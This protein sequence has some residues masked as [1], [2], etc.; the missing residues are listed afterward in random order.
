[1]S[2]ER[3]L[4]GE[5]T[6]NIIAEKRGAIGWLTFNDAERH[7]AVSF[8]MWEAVP[9]VL[10]AFRE[11]SDIRAVVLTGAGTKS[12]VSGANISQFDN[13]RSGEDAVKAYEVVAEAAQLALYDFEK[14]TLARIQGYCIGGGLNIAL[15]CDIRVASPD[16]SFAIPAGRLGLGYRLTAIRNL[17]T[18][19][20]PANA[21]EIFL[22][23]ARYKADEAKALGLIQRVSDQGELDAALESYLEK[24]RA[25]APLTLKA[26]KKMIRQMQQLGPQVD[27]KAM[28]QMVLD[29][30][31][32]E[33]YAEGK[34]AFAEKRAPVFKGR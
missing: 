31:A 27:V 33:D 7:N 2:S 30:F 1:M 22:S 8:A 11:D 4:Q 14:P 17:V 24:I 9:I 12:F 34:K 18:V 26:G 23:A 5:I 3:I 29:C 28:Q 25:N 21:L 13:L 20:G 32:S 19:V 10:N 15:C 6:D 16:S